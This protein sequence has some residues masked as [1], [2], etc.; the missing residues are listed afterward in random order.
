MVMMVMRMRVMVMT[1]WG[2]VLVDSATRCRCHP[3][4]EVFPLQQS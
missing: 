3:P 1:D 2:V 4:T